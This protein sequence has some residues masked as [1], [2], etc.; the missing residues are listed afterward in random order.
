MK[1]Y[2]LVCIMGLLSLSCNSQNDKI[3]NTEIAKSDEKT[4]E[5]PKGTWKVNKEFDENGN[6]IRFDS[7]YAWSS[8]NTDK[9]LSFA[10]HDSLMQSL[11]SRFS[12][13]FSGFENQGFEDIFSQ[14]SL[15]SKHFFGEDFSESEFGSYFSDMDDLRKQMMERQKKFLENYQSKVIRPEDEN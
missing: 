12:S 15:F 1:K 7:V 11:R 14:D 9:R 4:V 5:E 6:L 8:D 3:T 2:I 13:H 10:E